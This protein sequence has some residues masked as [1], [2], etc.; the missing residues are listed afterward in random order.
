MRGGET[1]DDV[2]G[3]F[4][5]VPVAQVV[6]N[7]RDG[8]TRDDGAR[9]TKTVDRSRVRA[10]RRQD[11]SRVIHACIFIVAHPKRKE[12]VVAVAQKR[13]RRDFTRG[14]SVDGDDGAQTG[15]RDSNVVDD[16]DLASDEEDEGGFV[17]LSRA[18]DD[19]EVELSTFI[20]RDAATPTEARY[21]AMYTRALY[22]Y[23]LDVNEI[24]FTSSSIDYPRRRPRRHRHRLS[25]SSTSFPLAIL[26]S[27]HARDPPLDL[28]KLR[29]A[30]STPNSSAHLAIK[31]IPPRRSTAR[32]VRSS[33]VANAASARV[34]AL[35]TR[36]FVACVSVI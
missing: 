29:A 16:V 23:I 7:V 12:L 19:G 25:S 11:E 8:F 35:C 20:A 36:S 18:D 22:C 10:R 14:W 21:S 27:L 1:Y 31:S 15:G 5:R 9:T 2:H 26:A 34:A 24:V 13:A 32:F 33:R 30:S 17:A 6:T 4:G 28:R 3:A